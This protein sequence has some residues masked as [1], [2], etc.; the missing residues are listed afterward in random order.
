MLRL[1]YAPRFIR[2]FKHL[3][4]DLQEEAIARIELFKDSKNHAFIKVH[5]LHGKLKKFYGFSV[6]F[7]NRIVFDYVSENEVV[8][9]TIGDHDIYN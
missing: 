3:P 4:K 2:Q 9:L 5:K 8:L 7:R 6:D 1:I